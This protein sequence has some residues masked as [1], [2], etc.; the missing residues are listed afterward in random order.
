MYS[1]EPMRHILSIYK[2]LPWLG[3]GRCD[4]GVFRRSLNGPPL[5]ERRPIGNDNLWGTPQWILDSVVIERILLGVGP[6]MD[7]VL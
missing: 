7:N 6:E 3:E 5:S 4:G 2:K 1:L